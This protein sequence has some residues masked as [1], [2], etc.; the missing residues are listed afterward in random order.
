MYSVPN[1]LKFS[2]KIISAKNQQIKESKYYTAEF[3]IMKIMK[4]STAII[5]ITTHNGI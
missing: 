1:C 2:I 3:F 4:N 5:K